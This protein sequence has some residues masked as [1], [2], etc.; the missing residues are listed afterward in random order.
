MNSIRSGVLENLLRGIGIDMNISKTPRTDQADK[1]I[2]YVDKISGRFPIEWVYAAFA[3]DLEIE[4][5]EY[6][7]WNKEALEVISQW[8]KVFDYINKNID[9]NDLGKSIPELCLKYLKERDE[10]ND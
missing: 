6:K 1:H 3:E 10:A 2:T 4:L 9:V 5:N 7:E 8:D